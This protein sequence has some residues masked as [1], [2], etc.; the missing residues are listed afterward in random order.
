MKVEEMKV[1]NAVYSGK[2]NQK[3]NLEMIYARDYEDFHVEYTPEQF[4]GLI[5]QPKDREG[6]KIK[7]ILLFSSGAFVVSTKGEITKEEV[8]AILKK[9]IEGE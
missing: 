1:V 8:E 6:S 2:I 7:N 3:V 4:P 9:I 5:I